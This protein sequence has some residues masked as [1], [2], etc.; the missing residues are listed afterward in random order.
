MFRL[1]GLRKIN[2]SVSADAQVLRKACLLY[3]VYTAQAFFLSVLEDGERT[4]EAAIISAKTL[5]ESANAAI[6]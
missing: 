5:K 1:K 4:G 3:L 6:T 2:K